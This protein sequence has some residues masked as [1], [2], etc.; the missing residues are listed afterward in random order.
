MNTHLSWMTLLH[1]VDE[2]TPH[3][4]ICVLFDQW[5]TQDYKSRMMPSLGLLTIYDY[6]PYILYDC[7]RKKKTWPYCMLVYIS[8]V[9]GVNL[10]FRAGVDWYPDFCHQL[11]REALREA[12]NVPILPV[13]HSDMLCTHVGNHICFIVRN[14]YS[15]NEKLGMITL[16][17]QQAKLLDNQQGCEP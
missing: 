16:L 5:S 10:G 8:R 11:L 9:L 17:A 15:G 4:S 2:G 13:Q 1:V 3:F 7:R 14:N 12:K 6:T